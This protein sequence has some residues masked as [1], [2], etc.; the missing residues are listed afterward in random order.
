MEADESMFT[1][2]VSPEA[3]P[4]VATYVDIDFE[5]GNPI[6]IDGVEVGGPCARVCAGVCG[7]AD[8]QTCRR[9]DAAARVLGDPDGWGVLAMCWSPCWQCADHLAGN[10][11][12]T[13][14][15]MC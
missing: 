5:K 10:V 13:L 2:S 1:R 14:L 11:L 6:A 15:A 12:I 7:R 8:V 3:A 4:D 9:V